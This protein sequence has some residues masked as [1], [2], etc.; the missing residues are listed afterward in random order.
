MYL[1]HTDPKFYDMNDNI[2]CYIQL[3]CFKLTLTPTEEKGTFP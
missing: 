3:L 2:K 1:T